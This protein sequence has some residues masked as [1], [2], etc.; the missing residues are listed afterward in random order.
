VSVFSC[1]DRCEFTSSHLP[2]LKV[3]VS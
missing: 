3:K 1:G 2:L